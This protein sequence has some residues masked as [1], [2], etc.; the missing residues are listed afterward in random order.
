MKRL[1]IS[2]I[3]IALIWYI[4][5]KPSND[6]DW[7]IDQALLPYAE[8]QGDKVDVYNIRNFFY[9]STDDFDI[10]YYDKTFDLNKLE[11]IYYI[12]EPFGN[13]GAAH[14][15][16]SFGFGPNNYLAISIEIRK[17]KGE[18][19]SAV[20]GLLK[21]YELAYVIADEKDV[22][23]LRSNYR[24]D[25]VLV[26]PVK[27]TKEK[28]RQLFVDM[29]TRANNLKEKPEFYNTITNTCTTNI[30]SHVN[31]ITPNKIPWDISLLLPENSD[32][33]AYKLG[34]IDTEL[35]LEE[36]RVKFLI[37]KKALKYADDPEFSKKIRQYD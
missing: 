37:N 1:V 18:S 5:I 11:S 33:L 31:K 30:A 7:A 3:V 12:I 23:K 4:S 13:I 6:R 21:R 20:K 36:A 32:A 15:F 17:E 19:F 2:L 24:K 27:S 35:S 10:N 29:L 28:R 26:Y 14:T 25:P 22:V 8:F 34:M 9:R 16:I